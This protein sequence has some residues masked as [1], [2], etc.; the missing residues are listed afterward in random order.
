VKIFAGLHGIATYITNYNAHHSGKDYKD[1][2]KNREIMLI[3]G[4]N[5][6]ADSQE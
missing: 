3:L 4:N 6:K 1:V 5:D 2:Y